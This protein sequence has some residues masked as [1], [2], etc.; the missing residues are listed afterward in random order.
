[1]DDGEKSELCRCPYTEG[2]DTS[3]Q[4]AT[5][6]PQEQ[7]QTVLEV[8]CCQ[9]D[10][11]LAKADKPQSRWSTDLEEWVPVNVVHHI[12]DVILLVYLGA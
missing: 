8:V 12:L 3:Q 1:M 11:K 6:Q 2:I 7:K 10:C 4:R 9:L 5:L